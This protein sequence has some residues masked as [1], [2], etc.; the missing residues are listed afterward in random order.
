MVKAR[1]A[2]ARFSNPLAEDIQVP[3][4]LETPEFVAGGVDTGWHDRW[5]AAR[6]AADEDAAS[7]LVAG[8]SRAWPAYALQPLGQ[9][10]QTDALER[11][12]DVDGRYPGRRP[13]RLSETDDHRR[14]AG[15]DGEK[16]SAPAGTMSA[17]PGG[18]LSA[19]QCRRSRLTRNTRFPARK[20]M[21]TQRA[22]GGAPAGQS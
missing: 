8:P 13:A 18:R 10:P 5:N 6:R 12:Q 9:L 20:E 22:N 14:H 16:L 17:G 7:A 4:T 2:D 11:S 1:S 21:F 15:P 3:Y 19:S